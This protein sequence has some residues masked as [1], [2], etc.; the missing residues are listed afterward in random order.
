MR[1][2]LLCAAL[3]AASTPLLAHADSSKYEQIRVDGGLTG[4]WVGVHGR[5]GSGMVVEIKA[6]VTDLLAIGGRVE[7][8]VQYGGDVGPDGDRTGLDVS[9]AACGLAKV[10]YF[11]VDG[12]VRPFVAFG[13]GGYTIGS[14]S[15]MDS[16]SGTSIHQQTGRYFGVAPQVGVDLGPV[17]VAATYNAILG[18]SLEVHHMVG[19]GTEHV[20]HVSQNYLSLELSF[21]FAGGR[22]PAASRASVTPCDAS[23][24]RC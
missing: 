2:R 20:E 8:A 9:M 13:A 5:N 12:P 17:R 10:E 11:L 15:I 24:Q 16:Q 14:Q 3:V 19:T 21:R 7:V 22:K 18:A 1:T 6:M 4:S 23:L